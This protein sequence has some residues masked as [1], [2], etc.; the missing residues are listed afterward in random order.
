MRRSHLAGAAVLLIATSAARHAPADD[1]SVATE[2]F[3]AGRDLMREGNFA[4]ACPK[5]AESARVKPTV[6]A[7]AKLA[8]CEEH[9]RRLVSAR[10]RWEQALNLARSTRDARQ[11]EA[12]REFARIDAKV[13][14]LLLHVRSALPPG[15]TIRV[16]ELHLGVA[17]L[18]VPL[19]VETGPHSIEVSAPG[20]KPWSVAVEGR[21]DGATT[22]LEIPVLE[23]APAARPAPVSV[24]PLPASTQPEQP[25]EGVTAPA[26]HG[27]PWQTVS[28]GVIAA[29][30]VVVGIGAALGVEAISQKSGAQC[31]RT[32]CPNDASAQKLED[33][34]GSANRSTAA[35]VVGGVLALGGLSLRLISPPRSREPPEPHVEVRAGLGGFSVSG[36]F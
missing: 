24:A 28:I 35:F 1:E 7:L 17:S 11:G 19:A 31:A 16:D 33:A 14:K 21:A 3:D 4:A 2:L 30:V 25:Q 18:E 20:K 22:S 34:Q 32:T 8:L 12:T 23:D 36:T 29:G 13:P 5:L 9:E 6:G 26:R 10:A 27:S 15:A